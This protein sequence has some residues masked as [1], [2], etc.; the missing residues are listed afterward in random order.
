MDRQLEKAYGIL[1]KVTAVI[2]QKW[3]DSEIQLL[4]KIIEFAEMAKLTCLSNKENNYIC[5]WLEP[6]MDFFAKNRQK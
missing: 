5:Q 2:S 6:F 1:Y 3:K 4:V